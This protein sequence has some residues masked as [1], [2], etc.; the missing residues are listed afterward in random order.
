MFRWIHRLIGWFRRVG[1]GPRVQVAAPDTIET[2]AAVHEAGHAI[3][4]WFCT[5]VV[6]VSWAYITPEGSGKVKYTCRRDPSASAAY[7]ET[8][9]CDL[10]ICLAGITAEIVVYG[11]TRS[12][13][14]A[15][16]L[17][18]ALGHAR[19]LAGSEAPWETS[20][21]V[22]VPFETAFRHPLSAA[23][24]KVFQAGYQMAKRLVL[25]RERQLYQLVSALLM[26]RRTGPAE[27]ERFLGSRF[28]ALIVGLFKPKFLV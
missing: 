24:F 7:S 21:S 2:R 23:E 13:P 18:E 3:A 20:D 14:A 16:D 1:P 15:K 27:M 12:G 6:E 8:K 22:R 11:K 28:T 17:E 10:V 5:N 26:W 9:W 4:A 19:A 25:S